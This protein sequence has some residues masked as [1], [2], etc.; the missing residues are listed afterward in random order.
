LVCDSAR[1]RWKDRAGFAAATEPQKANHV[2]EAVKMKDASVQRPADDIEAATTRQQTMEETKPTMAARS[3]PPEGAETVEAKAAVVP[4][5]GGEKQE[6]QSEEK[7]AR[8]LA[9]AV[10]ASEDVESPAS[11]LQE[12]EQ[13][14]IDY[15][16]TAGIQKEGST[17]GDSSSVPVEYKVGDIVEYRF[18]ETHRDWVEAEVK[19]VYDAGAIVL[20]YKDARQKDITMVLPRP[21][22]ETRVIHKMLTPA[23]MIDRLTAWINSPFSFGSK[24][25]RQDHRAWEVGKVVATHFVVAVTKNFSRFI[26]CRPSTLI[27]KHQWAE[28]L[29]KRP[30]TREVQEIFRGAEVMTFT[31]FA[32][33]MLNRYPRA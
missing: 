18:G 26:D 9:P 33:H 20:T 25:E 13:T 30:D 11:A 14:T 7:L 27:T 17:E 4:R 16:E 23:Q 28:Y 22:W 12:V 21:V 2:A 32:E 1:I 6:E 3:V 5:E 31:I 19:R 29:N 15:E 24:L 10:T 8:E